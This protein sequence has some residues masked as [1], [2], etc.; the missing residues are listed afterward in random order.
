V[1]EEKKYKEFLATQKS[2][3]DVSTCNA[4]NAINK[5]ENRNV[6]GLAATGIGGIDC[7]RHDMKRSCAVGDLQKG[8][9]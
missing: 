5:A 8:E 7:T 3:T 6:H 9:R 4:H 2:V 1:V